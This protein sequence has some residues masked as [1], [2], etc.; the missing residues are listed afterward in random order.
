M[1]MTLETM[2]NGLS[3]PLSVVLTEIE[4]MRDRTQRA[5]LLN[6]LTVAAEM[7]GSGR[8]VGYAEG[9]ES[10]MR[11]AKETHDGNA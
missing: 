11:A 6:M 3:T 5:Y 9:F 1:T 2:S 10:G 8:N 7:Y 4:G